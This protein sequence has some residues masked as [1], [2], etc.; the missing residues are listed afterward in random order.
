MIID[1]SL[2]YLLHKAYCLDEDAD[3]LNCGKLNEAMFIIK[4]HY[5]QKLYTKINF[6]IKLEYIGCENE[7]SKYKLLLDNK[8]IGYIY[9][10]INY[11][12]ESN[13][14]LLL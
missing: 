7:T 5:L 13:L 8:H 2:I 12:S 10:N 1:T 6:Q 9:E 14:I 11:E 3:F 4:L